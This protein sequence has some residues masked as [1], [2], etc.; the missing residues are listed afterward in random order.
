M[1]DPIVNVRLREAELDFILE[2]DPE[3]QPAG[4]YGSKNVDKLL[5][6]YR[7]YVDTVQDLI[8]GGVQE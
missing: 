2:F 1:S 8:D 3:D 7:R 6:D 5:A 4:N